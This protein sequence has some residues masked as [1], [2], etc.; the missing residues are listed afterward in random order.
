MSPECGD[1]WGARLGKG[2][3]TVDPIF[4]V[5]PTGGLR[6]RALPSGGGKQR[7]V[8]TECRGW[9]PEYLGSRGELGPQSQPYENPST[10]HNLAQSG[11]PTCCIS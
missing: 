3:Q 5:I 1:I 2:G 4:L 7:A 11:L 6:S 10:P 9:G 8:L